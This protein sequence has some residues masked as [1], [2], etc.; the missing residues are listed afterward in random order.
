VAE[1]VPGLCLD[2]LLVLTLAARLREVLGEALALAHCD[3]LMLALS[4]AVL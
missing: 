3:A 2:E 1:N 4:E